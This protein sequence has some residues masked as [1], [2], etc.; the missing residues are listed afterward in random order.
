MTMKTF[1]GIPDAFLMVMSRPK[2]KVYY[3]IF[4]YFFLAPWSRGRYA[5]HII[6][7]LSLCILIAVVLLQN[8]F[9]ALLCLNC[10]EFLRCFVSYGIFGQPMG[11]CELTTTYLSKT[12]KELSLAPWLVR[13]PSSSINRWCLPEHCTLDN[14]MVKNAYI[15]FSP[16]PRLLWMLFTNLTDMGATCTARHTIIPY[17]VL[18]LGSQQSQW[19]F[20]WSF[21]VWRS[22]SDWYCF[23]LELTWIY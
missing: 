20:L 2:S 1:S 3:C 11:F 18:S 14:R 8:K 15:S 17:M 5:P 19:Q 21:G 10:D 16:G 12:F 4:L 9:W 22:M 13:D 23:N 7:G 6:S